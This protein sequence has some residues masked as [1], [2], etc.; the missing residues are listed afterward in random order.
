MWGHKLYAGEQDLIPP[1]PSLGG[2]CSRR[3]ESPSGFTPPGAAVGQGMGPLP[4]G[5]V[6]AGIFQAWVKRHHGAPPLRPPLAP[7]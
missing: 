1:G 4:P 3:G 6:P 2:L 7:A 5:V